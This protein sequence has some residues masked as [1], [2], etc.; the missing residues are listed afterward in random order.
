MCV[1]IGQ[2][3]VAALRQ[4]ESPAPGVRLTKTLGGYSPSKA[5]GPRIVRSPHAG[6]ARTNF[7]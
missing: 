4:S 1:T 5:K 6:R 3:G 7:H 2:G